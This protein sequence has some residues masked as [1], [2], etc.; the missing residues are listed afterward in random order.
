M[1]VQMHLALLSPSPSAILSQPMSKSPAMPPP[2]LSLNLRIIGTD[3]LKLL[4]LSVTDPT[5]SV[6]TVTPLLPLSSTQLKLCPL[7]HQLSYLVHLSIHQ[8]S[9]T[10]ITPTPRSRTLFAHHSTSSLTIQYP[11]V[12]QHVVFFFSSH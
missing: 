1:N 11:N 12:Q 10:S 3:L 6:A 9:A 2:V 4:K 7:S 5:S 8:I